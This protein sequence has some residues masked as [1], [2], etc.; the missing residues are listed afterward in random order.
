[1]SSPGSATP[2]TPVLQNTGQ[3]EFMSPPG[4]GASQ[5]LDADHDEDVPLRYRDVNNLLGPSTPPGFAA[6]EL[7]EHLLLASEAEP[8]TFKEALEHENWRHAMLDEFTSIEANNTWELVD[9]PPGCFQVQSKTRRQGVCARQGID[10][11][12]VFAPV[13]RLESVR[14]LLAYAACEGGQYTAWMSSQ[15]FST[16][17]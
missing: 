5:H 7:E 12:E 17:N 4:T 6:R 1:M 8:A 11:D 9:R 13:A 3:V 15:H 14:L 10:F 16:V 2:R